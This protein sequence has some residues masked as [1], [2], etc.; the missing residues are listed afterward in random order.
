M[1]DLLP[2]DKGGLLYIHSESRSEFWS[3][4]LE[5]AYAKLHG[6]YEELRGG[7]TGEALVAFTGGCAET[8][9]TDT[10]PDN[11]FSH[12]QA[13]YLNLQKLCDISPN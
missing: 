6:G 1:D 9:D 8:W 13:K 7:G 4:L 11:L 10:A 3:A 5:K 2:C 12:I